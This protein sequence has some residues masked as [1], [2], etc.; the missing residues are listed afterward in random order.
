MANP[1]D[2]KQHV[3]YHT[4]CREA[5]AGTVSWGFVDVFRAR[6]PEPGQF[7]FFD[8]RVPNAL[9]RKLGWRV[10]H[11]LATPPLARRCTDAYIDLAPRRKSKPSDHT[12]LAAEFDLD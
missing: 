10:D 3:C 8:Y 12:V 2:H 6:H 11:I 4:A 7:T 5:F 9:K 1:A